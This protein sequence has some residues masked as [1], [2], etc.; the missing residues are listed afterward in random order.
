MLPELWTGVIAQ[1]TSSVEGQAALL[2]TVQ[3]N[4]VRMVATS[5]DFAET[6]QMIFKRFP[7]A[8]NPRTQRLL[9]ARHAGF[10]TD[11]HVFGANEIANH[12]LYSE[13]LIPRGYGSGVAT[14]IHYPSG[15]AVVVN[16]ER[17]A[18]LGPFGAAAVAR[19]DSLR[20]HLAR[21][22][23]VSMHLLFERA[24]TAVETLSGLGLAACA[25]TGSGTM[26]VANAE[27]DGEGGLWTSRGGDRMALLDRRA[28]ALLQEALGLIATEQGVRSL[29][30]AV[31]EGNLPAVLHVVPIRRAAHDLFGRAAAILVLTKA[32]SAPM[33]ATP[34]L[35]ALF[36]LAPVEAVVAA[37]I[38]AGLTIEQIAIADGKSVETVR[39]QVKSVLGK[40]G[41]HRQADLV[42][43]LAQLVPAGI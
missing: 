16:I 2:S 12:P 36:D 28:D 1:I 26:L 27:F 18:A 22:A 29:P 5:E 11:A 24:R 20:P 40:T 9:A 21:S 39:N 8:S 17:A 34:L 3:A 10:V 15:D 43:L 6:W 35:Q 14:A 25:V 13:I 7:G 37:R 42:R 41:C 38:A 31:R 23:L 33:R 19:L 30:I 32:S 4:S